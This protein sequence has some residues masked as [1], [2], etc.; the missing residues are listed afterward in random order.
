MSSAE[1]EQHREK[2]WEYQTSHQTAF[3]LSF[4]FAQLIAK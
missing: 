2:T 3:F 4:Q 1:N